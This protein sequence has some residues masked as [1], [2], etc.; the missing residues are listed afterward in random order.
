M[1]GYHGHG[2]SSAFN[3]GGSGNPEGYDFV[4][5][6][7]NDD[8]RRTRNLFSL[9]LPASDAGAYAPYTSGPPASGSRG[10]A[11]YAA[12]PPVF[13]SGAYP[14]YSVP[15]PNSSATPTHLGFSGLNLNASSGY[16]H[17]DEY[18]DML[19]SGQPQGGIGSSRAAP[20]DVE[21][22]GSG[23]VDAPPGR[24]QRRRVS[25]GRGGRRSGVNNNP[26]VPVYFPSL[27]SLRFLI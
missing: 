12:S 18:D 3:A 7:D 26:S 9:A 22:A 24:G 16:P 15:H 27:H 5:L 19:R 21:P 14:P 6:S 1:D 13:G 25:R 11:A 8:G 2:S 17:I 20:H 4:N 10:H 23:G